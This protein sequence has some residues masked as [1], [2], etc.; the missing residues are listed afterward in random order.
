MQRIVPTIWFNRNADEAAEFYADV[1]PDTLVDARVPHPE[2]GETLTVDVLIDGYRVTLLNG[3]PEFGP[4]PAISFFVNFDPSRME[5]ARGALDRLWNRLTDGGIVLMPLDR[6]DFSEHYGWVADRFGVN[7]QLMLTDPA[8]EPRPYI[9]PNLM[10]GGQARQAVDD[11]AALFP[12]AQVGTRVTYPDSGEVMFSEFQL[13]GEWFTAMDSAVEQP[14]TFTPGLSLMVNAHGQEEIDRLWNGLSAV[15]A[16][17]RC[18]WLQDRYGV[19]WQIVPD[20]MAELMARPG[21]Y[22]RMLGMGKL[23]IDEF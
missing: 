9:I 15:A 4:T 17:E 11:Y 2:S 20:N 19:S 18:G 3:G 10:Y 1:F 7:W 5:D 22:Q 21:A 12:G 16:L 8:G 14:F 23:V 13:Y 6:Y